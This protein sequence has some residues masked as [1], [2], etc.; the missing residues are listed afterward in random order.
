M[1]QSLLIHPQADSLSRNSFI[2]L[3]HTL[4]ER[5]KNIT[6]CKN[7]PKGTVV[8]CAPEVVVIK[9]NRA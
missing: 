5:V 7:P 3:A 8:M 9:A 4:L 6:H 1:S 2:L